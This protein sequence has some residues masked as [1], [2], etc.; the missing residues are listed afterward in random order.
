MAVIGTIRKQSAFL[1][2]II[3][4][5]LAAFVLGDFVKSG[6][7]GGR[8]VNIGIVNGEEITIMDFKRQVDRNIEATK[9]QQNKERLSTDESFTLR[10]DTWQQ[11][12]SQ[13]LYTK[14][15]EELGIEVSSEELF[16]LI[17]G[18]NPH[19]MVK[20]SFANPETGQFDRDLV[21]QFL[22]NVNADQHPK[23]NPPAERGIGI[24]PVTIHCAKNGDQQEHAKD[25]PCNWRD[26]LVFFFILD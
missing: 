25:G 3:G 2:I 7:S 12:V 16:D 5:A 15:Y 11:M 21:I 14:E 10:N 17:Q 4:V 23:H 26:V 9:Q 6:P 18:P 1:I 13:I 8:E 24:F 19:D 22:Q 20:Q